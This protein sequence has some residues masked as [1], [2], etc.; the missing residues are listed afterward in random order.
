MNKTKIFMESIGQ[1]GLTK[2]QFNAVKS[3]YEAINDFTEVEPSVY[4]PL[5]AK[6]GID[7]MIDLLKEHQYEVHD[8]SV[9]KENAYE[10]YR[11]VNDL[12]IYKEK[13]DE[14][15]TLYN[16]FIQVM[17]R[18]ENSYTGRVIELRIT[19]FPNFY[20]DQFDGRIF[21][22]DWDTYYVCQDGTTS[23]KSCKYKTG[24]DMYMALE[25]FLTQGTKQKQAAL[26]EWGDRQ[27]S[28]D[29]RN[30]FND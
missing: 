11:H 28:N 23:E 5:L 22:I 12:T 8:I 10:R 15:Y 16:V 13:A 4:E 26:A 27:L 2:S 9:Y 19:L 14:R 29:I 3:L 18:V 30:M 6:Y 24:D 20:N 17:E 21:F 7:K 25:N 1:L